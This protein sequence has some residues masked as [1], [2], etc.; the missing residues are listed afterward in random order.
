MALSSVALF[1]FI[2][3]QSISYMGWVAVSPKLIGIVGLVYC[4]LWVLSALGVYDGNV[5]RRGAPA[6]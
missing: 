4:V 3:L 5:G 2:L 6:A 1:L